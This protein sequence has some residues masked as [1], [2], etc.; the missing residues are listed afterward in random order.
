MTREKGSDRRRAELARLSAY[1]DAALLDALGE[2]ARAELA[3]DLLRERLSDQPDRVPADVLEALAGAHDISRRLHGGLT[4][5]LPLAALRAFARAEIRRRGGEAWR[6]LSP[7]HRGV[8]CLAALEGHDGEVRR[9]W[10]LDGGVLASETAGGERL[11]WHLASG[12]RLAP[13]RREDGLGTR[14]VLRWRSG[15]VAVSQPGAARP[16]G[17]LELPAGSIR[18]VAGGVLAL[19]EG[20]PDAAALSVRDLA[21]GRVMWSRDGYAWDFRSGDVLDVDLSP[22]GRYVAV[23]RGYGSHLEVVEIETGRSEEFASS[24]HEACLVA[25]AEE[26]LALLSLGDRLVVYDLDAGR[27]ALTLDGTGP[28]L[29]AA[30]GTTL[31]RAVGALVE[32]RA[33]DGRLLWQRDAA[34]VV[35]RLAAS[36]SGGLVAALARES[37][38]DAE[39]AYAGT[40]RVWDRRGGEVA[41]VGGAYAAALPGECEVVTGGRWGT[42]WRWAV[43]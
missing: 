31:L 25:L 19:L 26:P 37:W 22:G 24:T 8:R 16:A 12:R 42:L 2:P 39:R 21:T 14:A 15:S 40:L 43:E 20:G 30:G 5:P 36:P 3:A 13:L 11:L 18:A 9:M 38:A 1:T 4:G 33:R 23:G 10:S 6:P 7:P 34:G 27:A 41:A 28:A 32:A 17:R 29:L 35:D